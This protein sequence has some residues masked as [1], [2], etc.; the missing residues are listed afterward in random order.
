MYIENQYMTLWQ[1]WAKTFSLLLSKL[2]KVQVPGHQL[3]NLKIEGLG[4]LSSLLIQ[5]RGTGPVYRYARAMFDFIFTDSEKELSENGSPRV[6]L[7]L[8]E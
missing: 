3:S 4:L 7:N 1:H 2:R 5:R 8:I 6:C